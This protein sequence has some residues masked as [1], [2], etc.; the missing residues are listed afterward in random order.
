MS[1]L[2]PAI[3][4]RSQSHMVESLR[5]ISAIHEVHI[6]IVDGQFAGQPSWPISPAGMVADIGPYLAGHSVEIDIMTNDPLTHAAPWQALGV[7]MIVVHVETITVDT[8]ANFVAST[9]IS[10][11][12]S[13]LLDTPYEVLQPYLATADYTQVMGIR[14]IGAQ[15]QPFDEQALTRI[16]EIHRDFP[17]LLISIDGSVN[18]ATVTKLRD[19]PI[20]RFVVG[21]AI[22]GA[23]NPLQAYRELQALL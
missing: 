20:A 3:I 23:L 1:A 5:Q 10:I 18:P 4:P 14:T 11:G 8:F 19:L 2:V 17:S 13:A 16:M 12:V 9:D 15:G 6:D 7:D 22:M 21:S